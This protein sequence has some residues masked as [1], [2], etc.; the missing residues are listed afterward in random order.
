MLEPALP[1]LGRVRLDRGQH[2]DRLEARGKHPPPRLDDHRPHSCRRLWWKLGLE[3]T[4]P[5]QTVPAPLNLLSTRAQVGP[6][7][8]SHPRRRHSPADRTPAAH[9]P[10]SDPVAVLTGDRYSPATAQST[11][12]LAWFRRSYCG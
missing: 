8:D 3:R 4:L 6:R 5:E 7:F 9:R 1:S 2:V 11:H 12:L 10:V